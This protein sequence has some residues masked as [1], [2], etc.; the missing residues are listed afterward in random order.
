MS[1]KWYL[2]PVKFKKCIYVTCEQAIGDLPPLIDIIGD[3]NQSYPCEPQSPYQVL[4]RSGSEAIYM[5]CL[6]HLYMYYTA[7]LSTNTFSKP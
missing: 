5:Y 4:M 6:T 7:Y 1:N 2:L 3:K